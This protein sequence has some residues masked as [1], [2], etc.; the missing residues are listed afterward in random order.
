MLQLNNTSPFAAEMFGLP[1]LDGVDHLY[2]VVKATFDITDRG[3]CVADEQQPV[4]LADEYFAEPGQSSLRYASQAHLPK[5][6]TDVVLIGDACAPR[7]RPVERVDV[8]VSV[9]GRSKSAWVHG[10]RHWTEGVGGIRPSQPRPFV[11]VPVVY[12]RTFGGTHVPDPD[13]DEYQAEPRNPV[14]CG[15][16]G[17]RSARDLL[18]Q[19]VPNVELPGATVGAPATKGT[20]VGFGPI[21]PSWQPRSSHAGT[22][23]EHW[24]QT[25]A[26]FL[27]RDFDPRFF[28]VAPEPLLFPVPLRG[29]EPVVMLGFHPGGVQR[30]A[31]PRCEFGVQ[32]TMGS[33]TESIELR[34]ET[35]ML[36]PTDERVSL[37]WRGALSADKRM[38]RIEQIAVA[39]HELDG[40]HPRRTA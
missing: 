38:L 26:P 22:Y 18:G 40:A 37:S 16:L 17:K 5:P 25:R 11:R 20:P 9:A 7:E 29:G 3:L 32:A 19:P 30:F 39:L 31:L 1:D 23:D 2:V 10:D 34:L 15:F 28:H 4:T 36:E 12:E 35:V 33:H 13:R 24:E 6:G 8:S 21:A 14:G 27:P